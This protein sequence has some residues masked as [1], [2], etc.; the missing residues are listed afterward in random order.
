VN[1]LRNGA[2]APG[3]V[4]VHTTL[5]FDLKPFKNFKEVVEYAIAT[6]GKSRKEIAAAL[7]PNGIAEHRL[8]MMLS[9]YEGTRHFPLSWLPDLIRALGD[10]GKIIV[11]WQV[12]EFLLSPA[13][14]L[15]QAEQILAEY[16]EAL[17]AL[18]KAMGILSE[19]RRGKP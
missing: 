13:E 17:P 7:G 3:T 18:Q 10:A 5:S 2:P 9:E 1:T 4:H 14:R 16:A 11:Q 12:N 6:S 15:T 19:S 8:S